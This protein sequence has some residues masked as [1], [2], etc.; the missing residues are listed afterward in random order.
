MMS[1]ERCAWRRWRKASPPSAVAFA[2]LGLLPFS[3]QALTPKSPEVK[4]SVAK[5]VEYLANNRENFGVSS[6][7]RPGA[8]VLVGLVMIKADLPNH[9]RIDDALEAIKTEVIPNLGADV[10]TVGLSLIFLSELPPER[11]AM[12]QSELTLVHQRLIELQKPFGGW[13]YPNFGTGDTSMTQYGALGLWSASGAGLETPPAVW[14][15][16]ANWLIRTQAPDGGFGYQGIDPGG[17]TPVAQ[18]RVSLSMC[19]AGAASLYVCADHFGLIAPEPE[20]V[21]DTPAKMKRIKK[22][23]TTEDRSTGSVDPARLMGAI[24]K[25]NQLLANFL[26]EPTDPMHAYPYYYIYA[27]ER[28]RS[29]RDLAA[30]HGSEDYEPEWYN[31]GARHLMSKQAENGSWRANETEV[32]IVPDTCFATLFLLRSTRKSIIR[33]KHLGAGTLVGGKG[34][35]ENMAEVQLRGGQLKAKKLSASAMKLLGIIGDPN[36]PNFESAVVGIEEDGIDPGDETLSD[37]AKRLRQLAKGQSPQSRA[38]ALQALARTRDLDQAPLLIEALKDPDP[39][40]FSAANDGLRFMSRKFYG[41]GFWGG[42]DEKTRQ[43]AIAQWKA[44]Y[45]SIRPG[46][47]LD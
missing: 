1:N 12:H 38:A 44:W 32:G 2:I 9:P 36:D 20:V 40:V 17:Y 46:A 10:Y 3:A 13:G 34:L 5:A 26:P 42:S 25:S 22:K 14:Q 24:A 41:A 19:T 29:F 4:A 28:Y 23:E 8:R 39:L 6:K 21:D 35:P 16:L 30:G 37:V 33:I 18:N 43:D 15:K 47:I 27:A 7:G 31:V 45:L 11:Q